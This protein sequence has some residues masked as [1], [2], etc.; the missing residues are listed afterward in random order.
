MCNIAT[1]KLK[2]IY[3][4]NIILTVLFAL[5]T[6][7]LSAAD[8]NIEEKSGWYMGIGYG[9]TAYYDDDMGKDNYPN[10]MGD[11]DDDTDSGVALYGGYKIN[12][13]VSIEASYRDYGEF[14][15]EGSY[16]ATMEATSVA[17]SGNLGYPFLDNQLRPFVIL[18]V[19]YVYTDNKNS[20]F[21]IVDDDT[22]S[23]HIGFGIEYEP[24]SLNGLGFR[25]AYEADAY[26]VEVVRIGSDKDY[27]VALGQL[28][29][30]VQYRF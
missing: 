16:D 24:N 1:F 29:F 4:K 11:L 9:G 12:N 21:A 10:E 30:G 6:T 15:Y 23:L 14:T 13:Y 27:E 26:T 7:T 28:Y 20:A 3:M 19:G 5:L 18:G 22:A 17:L 8:S 25:L 2:G